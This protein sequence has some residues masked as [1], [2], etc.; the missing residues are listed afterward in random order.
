[1]KSEAPETAVQNAIDLCPFAKDFL[2][3]VSKG[4]VPP[5]TSHIH[6]QLKISEFYPSLLFCREEI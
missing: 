3:K 4:S 1:M 5:P 6:T 2:T